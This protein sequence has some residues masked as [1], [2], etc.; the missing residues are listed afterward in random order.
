[1][2][3]MTPASVRA[4]IMTLLED[5]DPW[6]TRS[7][8]AF[9][10]D[11]QPNAVLDNSYTLRQELVKENSQTS[12]VTARIDRVTL[13]IGRLLKTD[14]EAAIRALQDVLD[15]VDRRVRADGVSQGYHV[16][17]Q[18]NRITRPDGRDYCLGELAWTCDYDFSE[19]VV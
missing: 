15:D 8:E 14:G 17:P 12:N 13:T 11:R 1:M 6:L 7:A 4:R 5:S 2:A 9:S 16:W 3:A 10:L 19:T 18:S